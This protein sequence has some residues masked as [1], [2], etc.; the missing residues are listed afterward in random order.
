[1][2]CLP[3]VW[4]AWGQSLELALPLMFYA[5]STKHMLDHPTLETVLPSNFVTAPFYRW[6]TEAEDV[7]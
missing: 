1:M 5:W 7:S 6:E 3:G 2:E 4:E